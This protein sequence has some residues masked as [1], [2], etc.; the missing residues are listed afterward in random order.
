MILTFFP[1]SIGNFD[2]TATSNDFL[3]SSVRIA[4]YLHSEITIFF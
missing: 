4:T 2:V 1:S 3:P